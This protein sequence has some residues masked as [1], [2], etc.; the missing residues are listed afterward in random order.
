MQGAAKRRRH[1][2]DPELRFGEQLHGTTFVC[3]DIKPAG[4]AGELYIPTIGTQQPQCDA[5]VFRRV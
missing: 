3:H 5:R 2:D 1:N 4:S